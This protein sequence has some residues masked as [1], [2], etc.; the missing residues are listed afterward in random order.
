VARRGN[1]RFVVVDGREASTRYGD[2]GKGTLVFSPD[3][4]RI[5]YDGMRDNKH[6]VVVDGTEAR[7]YDRAACLAFS[8]DSKHVALVGWHSRKPVIVVDGVEETRYDGFLR[9]GQLV[10]DSPNRFHT[11]ARRGEEFFLADVKIVPE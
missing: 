10:F 8:P 4:Q 3:S 6:F 11:L 9:G 5:A 2:I 1:G 7:V